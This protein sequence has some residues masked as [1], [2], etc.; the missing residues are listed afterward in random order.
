M[1]K[2]KSYLNLNTFFIFAFLIV[3]LLPT[4][5][6]IDKIG[7]QWLYLAI[8]NTLFYI[9]YDL[10]TLKNILSYL[11][12]RL[13]FTFSIFLIIILFSFL[14]SN[15]QIESLIIFSR[16]FIIFLSFVNLII[17]FQE[18]NDFKLVI[19]SILT[20]VLLVELTAIFYS[21]FE[22]LALAKYNLSYSNFLIGVTGNKNVAASILAIKIPFVFYLLFNVRHKIFKLFITAVSVLSFYAIFIMNSRTILL[23]LM[24]SLF[25]F[26]LFGI[27]LKVSKK[28]LLI[29]LSALILFI[30]VPFNDFSNK[31]FLSSRLSVSDNNS[32]ARLDFYDTAFSHF[33]TNPFIGVGIGN[34]K[35]E[36]LK[37]SNH[38]MKDYTVAYHVHN[39][40]LEI[41]VELGIFG[42]I[43]YLFLF[44]FSFKFIIQNRASLFNV[45]LGCSLIIYFFDSMLNFPMSRVSNQILFVLLLA[46]IVSLNKTQNESI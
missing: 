30:S 9:F 41:A 7:P 20:L 37:Y 35:I 21:Y 27:S 16:W 10:S 2:I 38:L 6:S 42:F 46:S 22:I 39:D 45:L 36:S 26:L 33:I 24:V 44:V 8:L 23:G 19:S 14:F 1:E 5:G 17:L 12:H 13:V 18:S 43:S 40:F 31:A 29:P 15:N 28:W 25:F 4:F 3:G 34:W 32:L 11:S